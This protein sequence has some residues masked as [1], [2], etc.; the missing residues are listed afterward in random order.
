[1]TLDELVRK[2]YDA[3]PMPQFGRTEDGQ[4]ACH[5]DTF[6]IDTT[7]AIGKVLGP[8]IRKLEE[9]IAEAQKDS[10]RL[11]AVIEMGITIE[12]CHIGDKTWYQAY[13]DDNESDQF[14]TWREAIDAARVKEQ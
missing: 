9:Q 11:K 8:E 13:T 10:E 5:I 2:V 12:T 6:P 3:L 1:M 14:K 4:V 7:V